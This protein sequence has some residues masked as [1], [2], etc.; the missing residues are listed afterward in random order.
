LRRRNRFR[1]LES[2]RRFR[3]RLAVALRHLIPAEAGWV[4]TAQVAIK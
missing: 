4:T 1:I 3:W 2:I